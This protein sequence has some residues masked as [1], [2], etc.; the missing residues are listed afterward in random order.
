[1]SNAFLVGHPRCGTTAIYNFMK[2]VPDVAVTTPKELRYFD[3]NYHL[4][5]S[6]YQ[7]H[8]DWKHKFK[9]D[10]I[11]LDC[12]VAHSYVNFTAKRIQELY[13]NAKIVQIIRDPFDRVYSWWKLFHNMRYGR[14]PR[15]FVDFLHGD[16]VTYN[17]NR[18]EYEGNWLPFLDQAGNTYQPFILESGAYGQTFQRFEKLFGFDNVLLMRYED[19]LNNPVGFMTL[20]LYFIGSSYEIE[21]G[22]V[23]DFH[24]ID[25][26]W[27]DRNK[28]NVAQPL[29]PSTEQALRREVREFYKTEIR[30]LEQVSGRDF[31]SYYK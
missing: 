24:H 10:G 28:R 2:S 25:Q 18:F 26:N 11:W 12:N 5:I 29:G 1:M 15:S 13:P 27:P 22:Q 19:F 31:G 23:V 3:N 8:F 6:W 20:I 9:T 16:M 17:T 30:F 21:K 4:P 7:D 14:E